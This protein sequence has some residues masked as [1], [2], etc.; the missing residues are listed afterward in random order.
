MTSSPRRPLTSRAEPTSWSCCWRS[1]G[2]D[3]ESL[4]RYWDASALVPLMVRQQQS[5]AAWQELDGHRGIITWWGT[6]IECASALARLIREGLMQPPAADVSRVRFRLLADNWEE[7][8]A[9]EPVRQ[10]AL[11]LLRTHVLRS[12]DA[13]QLAAAI[14]A[15]EGAPDSLAFVTLDDRLAEAASKEGFPIVM[16]GSA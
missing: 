7:V 11:R 2:P 4:V 1:E 15:C 14:A 5:L 3:G 16:P 6:R 9:S 8:G 12:G 13:L 10:T